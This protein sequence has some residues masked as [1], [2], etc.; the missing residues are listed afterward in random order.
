[1]SYPATN[2]TTRKIEP[3]TSIERT[4]ILQDNF[5]DFCE[6][7]APY[8]YAQ[9]LQDAFC[10]WSSGL[11]TNGYFVEFG[12]L[13]GIN[14]SNTYLM[15]LLGW[16]GIVAEP[17]PSYNQLIHDNRNCHVSTDCVWIETG[18]DIRFKAVKGKPALSTIASVNYDDVQEQAGARE[19][20]IEHIVN[21][22]TLN[23]LLRQFKAPFLIDCLSIDTEGS[24]LEI[25]QAFDFT[26]HIFGTIV[27]EH[28]FSSK[29]EPIYDLLTR[30][31]YVR[32]WPNL[33]AHDDWYVHASYVDKASV[34]T[35]RAPKF[36]LDMENIARSNDLW[37]R[38]RQLRTMA[39]A[40]GDDLRALRL[41]Q[42]VAAENTEHAVVQSEFAL[43]LA[44]AGFITKAIEMYRHALTLNPELQVTRN[45]LSV[46]RSSGTLL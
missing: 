24:E 46:L 42:A 11:K 15:E 16:Q 3:S 37:R 45:Q 44:R 28:G 1:M 36:L 4:I 29:R 7:I 25:L 26:A 10:L 34:S 20:F 35:E 5:L 8:S 30:N 9:H 19:D 21:S 2:L 40:V 39:E 6:N 38:L 41:A 31:G 27:V 22:I 14:V 18:A 17:H 13:N 12:A 33:S 23:D 43:A 32:L